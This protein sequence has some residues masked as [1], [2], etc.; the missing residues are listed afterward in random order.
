MFM[1]LTLYVSI[2][3][4]LAVVVLVVA[5]YRMLVARRD[6]QSLDVTEEDSRVIEEQKQAI[7]KIRAI[8]RWGKSLTVLTIAYGLVIAIVY[9]ANVWQ[10]AT[11]LPSR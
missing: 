9:F 7:K 11:K 10:E 2:W 8:D 1:S 5:G 3:V 6:D 4:L